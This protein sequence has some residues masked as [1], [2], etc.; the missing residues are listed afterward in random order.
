MDPSTKRLLDAIEDHRRTKYGPGRGTGPM[1]AVDK[2]LYG[3][4][5]AVRARA[6]MTTPQ[7]FEDREYPISGD[8]LG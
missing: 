2:I 4:S 7:S 3:E 8:S 5:D 6:G 1:F